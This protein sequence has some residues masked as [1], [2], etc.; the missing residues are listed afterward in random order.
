MTEYKTAAEYVDRG[1]NKDDQKDSKGAIEDYNKAIELIPTM[2]RH[3]LIV[4]VQKKS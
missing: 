1:C 4:D 2:Q 3:M